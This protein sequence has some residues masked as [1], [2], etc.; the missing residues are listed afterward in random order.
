MLSASSLVCGL[1]L[2]AAVSV[3]AGDMAQAANGQTIVPSPSKAVIQHPLV[4]IYTLSTCPHCQEAKEYMTRHEIPYV[5]REVDSNDQHM[6][7]LM[8]IYETMN[9]PMEKRGVPL[10][11]IADQIRL[12][13]FNKERFQ[14]ELDRFRTQ[15]KSPDVA[16]P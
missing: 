5:N 16:K 7:E 6:Q 14:K 4:V 9:V 11:I 10:I 1:L 15:R 8:Q 12:Q 3:F 2:S 13:G